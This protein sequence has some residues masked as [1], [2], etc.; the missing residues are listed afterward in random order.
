MSY[1]R[2]Y[3]TSVYPGYL[4]LIEERARFKWKLFTYNTVEVF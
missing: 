3:I 1:M 4:Q 2:K